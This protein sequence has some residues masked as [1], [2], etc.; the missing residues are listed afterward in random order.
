[1]ILSRKAKITLVSALEYFSSPEREPTM[2]RSKCNRFTTKKSFE[3]ENVFPEEKTHTQLIEVDED[4][5]R[6][7]LKIDFNK[8]RN[9]EENTRDNVNP[10]RRKSSSILQILERKSIDKSV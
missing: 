6:T 3:C 4:I 9:P 8:S 5:D 7:F 2:K 10:F 1:M